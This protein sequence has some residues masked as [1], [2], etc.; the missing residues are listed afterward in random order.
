MST[1]AKKIMRVLLPFLLLVFCGLIAIV[2]MSSAQKPEKK[3]EVIK[4]PLIS[5]YEVELSDQPLLMS[6]YGVVRPKHKT[7]IV[8]QVSGEVIEISPVF[9]S[10]GIVEKGT[11]LAQI[12]PSDY[13]AALIEAQANLQRAKAALQ[14]EEARGIVAKEEWRGATSKLPPALGLRKPQLAREQANLR[15]AEAS[16]ARAERN[17]ART[18]IVAPYNAII[19]SRNIDLGQFAGTGSTLGVLSS[20]DTAE[21]R[22]PISSTDYNYLTD[23]QSGTV[24]LAREEGNGDVQWQGTIIRDEG[25]I[26]ENSRMIY[27]VAQIEQPYEQSPSLKF[28]TFVNA[29]IK[30]KIHS[31]IAVIPNHLYQDGHVTMVTNTRQLHKQ[32]VTLLKRD[33]KNV[34]ILDGLKNGDLLLDSKLENLYEGMKV[35]V[36]GDKEPEVETKT[37]DVELAS[38][39]IK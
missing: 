25:V 19:N 24:S 36:D 4:A 8:A 38:G 26:D 30:S 7:S 23:T 17:L 3:E 10:G 29:Q 32:P 14:E 12:D 35:R 16:L 39:D 15:S 37:G 13:K 22:L 5:T 2:I 33:K 9:A 20:I 27:I 34:Y 1:S 6:S 28:G 18:K 11:V 21:V 31:N